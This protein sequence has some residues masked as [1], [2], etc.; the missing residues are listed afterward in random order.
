MTVETIALVSGAVVAL[1]GAIKAGPSIWRF[2]WAAYQLPA[3]IA[4]MLEQLRGLDQV[5]AAADNA[6]EEWK[7]ATAAVRELADNHTRRLDDHHS[8]LT[9]LERWRDRIEGEHA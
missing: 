6:S 1:A 5:K 7:G 8:R 9:S 2:V 4:E 3:H